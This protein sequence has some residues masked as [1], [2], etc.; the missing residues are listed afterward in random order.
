[1]SLAFTLCR[2]LKPA[3]TR[4]T[5]ALMGT[6]TSLDQNGACHVASFARPALV[7]LL[8]HCSRVP[9]P[10]LLSCPF[11]CYNYEFFLSFFLSFFRLHWSTL[12]LRFGEVTNRSPSREMAE[13]RSAVSYRVLQ[14]KLSF[15]VSDEEIV[16]R[17]STVRPCAHCCIHGLLIWTERHPVLP[18]LGSCEH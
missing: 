10:A 7:S 2:N 4:I 14:P 1:M 18:H 9:S 11:S 15:V 6:G 3:G 16:L 12:R 5:C 17:I 8:L 13:A